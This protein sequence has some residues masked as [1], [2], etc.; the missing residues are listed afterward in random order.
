MHTAKSATEVVAS[1]TA[2]AHRVVLSMMMKRYVQ[3]PE[4]GRGP[5]KSTR[6]WLKRRPGTGMCRC[7][8][9]LPR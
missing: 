5:T 9:I 6:T 1:G 8:T 7:L 2:S 4:L 3:P